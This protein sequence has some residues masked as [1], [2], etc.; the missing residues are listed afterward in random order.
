MDSYGTGIQIKSAIE[1]GVKKIII[2]LGGSAT[3]DGASGI[4][5]ALGVKFFNNGKLIDKKNPKVGL[6]DLGNHVLSAGFILVVIFIS[7][8]VE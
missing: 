3:I 1:I 4:L 6:F 7:L 5:R 8:N 2:S